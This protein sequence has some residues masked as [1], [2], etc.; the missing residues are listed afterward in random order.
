MSFPETI[1]IEVKTTTSEAVPLPLRELAALD[2][3]DSNEI[4]ILAAL[5]WCGDRDVDG[6]WLIEQGVH[7]NLL[8]AGR[9]CRLALTFFQLCIS[10]TWDGAKHHNEGCDWE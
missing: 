9:D 8:M 7:P 5:F 3:K 10:N 4:G 1:R 2:T 6:R